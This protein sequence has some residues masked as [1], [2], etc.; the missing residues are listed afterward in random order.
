MGHARQ[1]DSGDTL[2][3]RR[4][5]DVEVPE[6]PSAPVPLPAAPVMSPPATAAAPIVAPPSDA[7]VLFGLQPAADDGPG[8]LLRRLHAGRP[9]GQLSPDPAAPPAETDPASPALD[10]LA[11]ALRTVEA[12]VTGLHTGVSAEL[13]PEV[14]DALAERLQQSSTLSALFP[15]VFLAGTVVGIAEDAVEA[16]RGVIDLVEMILDIDELIEQATEILEIVV[17]PEGGELGRVLGE[18]LGR[19]WGQQL[20]DLSTKGVFEFTYELGKIAGPAIVYTIAS[21]LGLPQVAA[22]A[23]YARVST[24]LLPLLKRFPRLAKLAATLAKRLPH[25]EPDLPN[26]PAGPPERTHPHGATQH[27]PRVEPDSRAMPGTPRGVRR[28]RRA[29][30]ARCPDGKPRPRA[31]KRAQSDPEAR[32]DGRDPRQDRGPTPE[33]LAKFEQAPTR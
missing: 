24:A 28:L 10:G 19:G 31:A 26:A 33:L 11:N 5:A 23:A 2:T 4:P 7:A 15:Q 8:V 18:Q 27:L 25:H 21:F 12:L 29:A 32:L 6:A 20:V 1:H 22:A 30:P 9:P 14:A 16:V 17:S 13:T 3:T